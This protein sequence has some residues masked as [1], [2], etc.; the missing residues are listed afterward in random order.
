LYTRQIRG[1]NCVVLRTMF[2]FWVQNPSRSAL[3]SV[4]FCGIC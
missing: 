2:M 1:Q 3:P 4:S